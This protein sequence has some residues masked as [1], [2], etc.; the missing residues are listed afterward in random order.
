MHCVSV[1]HILRYCICVFTAALLYTFLLSGQQL[2]TSP[3]QM[4][5]GRDW[6]WAD[7]AHSSVWSI[8]DVRLSPACWQTDCPVTNLIKQD[9]TVT[10]CSQRPPSAQAADRSKQHC[11]N[12]IHYPPSVTEQTASIRYRP[13]GSPL[14]LLHTHILT[15][16]ALQGKYYECI[17]PA[18]LEQLIQTVVWVC[19]Q[20]RGKQQCYEHRSKECEIVMLVI[21]GFANRNN[22]LVRMPIPCTNSMNAA[23]LMIW[24]I[25]VGTTLIAMIGCY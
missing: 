13:A 12:Q 16:K 22:M 24:F 2:L 4:A 5:L 19:T 21:F 17:T 3:S 18:V 20:F 6:P 1:I 11:H 7:E 15:L 9:P 10:Q 8:W 23:L 25:Q 14:I